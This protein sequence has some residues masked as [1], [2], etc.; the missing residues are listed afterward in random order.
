MTIF[1]IVVFTNFDYFGNCY[2]YKLVLFYVTTVTNS[3]FYQEEYSN[4]QS[5][6]NCL[7]IPISV[8][9]QIFVSSFL[10]RY[11]DNFCIMHYILKN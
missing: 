6:G 9:F 2:F 1:K 4:R 10:F 11:I 8:N 5:P 7:F 3:F